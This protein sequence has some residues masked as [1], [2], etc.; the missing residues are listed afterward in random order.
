[1]PQT[2]TAVHAAYGVNVGNL[3]DTGHSAEPT[4]VAALAE[5]RT[6]CWADLNF[7]YW[8]NPAISRPL[9]ALRHEPAHPLDLRKA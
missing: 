1:M 3:R 5:K 8:P 7:R 4:P 2:K 6:R 9:Y